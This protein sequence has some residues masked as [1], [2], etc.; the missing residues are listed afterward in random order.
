MMFCPR[1][2]EVHKMPSRALPLGSNTDRAPCRGRSAPSNW[3]GNRLLLALPARHLK[4]LMPELEHTPCQRGHVLIDADGSLDHVFFPNRGVVS[5]V[6]VYA[7]GS[8]I[9]MATI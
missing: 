5:A 3:V 7:D 4:R 6:A 9:E 2:A 8:T 1:F